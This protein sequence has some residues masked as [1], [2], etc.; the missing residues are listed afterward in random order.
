[1]LCRRFLVGE[2]RVHVR[3][4]YEACEEELKALGAL[5]AM[6]GLGHYNTRHAAQLVTQVFGFEP[7]TADAT[8]FWQTH[9]GPAAGQAER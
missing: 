4:H 9:G 6:R 8:F 1:M 3:A 5:C 7:N 2:W